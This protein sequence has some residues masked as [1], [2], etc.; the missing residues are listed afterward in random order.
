MP[1]TDEK[2]TR[3]AQCDYLVD[4]M[5]PSHSPT[6]LEPAHINNTRAWDHVHCEPFL[7]GA[8]THVL[9]RLL[10]LPDVPGLPNQFRRQWGDYCLLRRR[11]G[12]RP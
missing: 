11:V 3:L 7:D 8:S 1:R 4:S 12:G 10:W 6:A 5:V 2:Q 9:G